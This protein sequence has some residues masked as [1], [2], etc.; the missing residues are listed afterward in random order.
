MSALDPRTRLA[1]VLNVGVMALVLE[2]PGA[3]GVLVGVSFVPFFSNTRWLGRALGLSAL[4][5]WSTVVSQ[6]LF[7]NAEP[8][9]ALF[10]VGGLAVWREGVTYGLVQSM[11]VVAV[12]LAGIALS[13]HT[14][15]DRLF[16]AL[17][18][19]RVPF[20]LA[21][22][23]GTA[24]RFLPELG[25]A[26]A[27]VRR[28]RARRGRPA[29]HR[30][31]WGWLILEVGLLRPLV[32]RAIRRARCLGES[33]DARGFDPVAPRAVRRPLVFKPLEPWLMG[34]VTT[35]TL[36]ALS[37][38][39]LYLLYAWDSVYVASLRPMYALVRNWL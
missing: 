12:G 18:R 11:R 6:A 30:S 2:H 13:V 1:L 31:P 27:V 25:S 29:L 14:P 9:V 35:I 28:A 39:V 17:L 26:W 32:A 3:L 19:L 23:A 34:L 20:G 22:M 15:P 21:L 8:R 7:Y 5:V 33:L 10:H 36:M 37:M 24:F 4:V 16:A 38:R